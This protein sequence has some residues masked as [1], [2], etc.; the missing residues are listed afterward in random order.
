MATLR[1]NRG[2]SPVLAITIY[3]TDEEVSPVMDLTGVPVTIYGH[4]LPI[5]PTIAVVDAVAGRVDLTFP[6]TSPMVSF[7]SYE[8]RLRVG[9]AGAPGTFTVDF[10]VIAE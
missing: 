2:S 1:I 5:V 3:E 7:K 9:A 8:V 6:D 4:N 10:E